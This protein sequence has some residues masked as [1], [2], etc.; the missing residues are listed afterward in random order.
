LA[1]G[2]NAKQCASSYPH[3]HTKGK[4]SLPLSVRDP[5]KQAIQYYA[6]QDDCTSWRIAFHEASPGSLKI[7]VL[8]SCMHLQWGCQ[9]PRLLLFM[10]FAS[11]A[12]VSRA[13][14]FGSGDIG[15]QLLCVKG[16][17]E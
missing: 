17:K 4:E 12:D 8:D 9:T 6:T 5:T 7:N 13:M 1:T 2:C 3:G 11:G 10:A 14:T 15:N 16:H